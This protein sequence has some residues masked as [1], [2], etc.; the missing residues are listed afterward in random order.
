MILGLVLTF[1]FVPMAFGGRHVFVGYDVSKSMYGIWEKEKMNRINHYLDAILFSGLPK[2]SPKDRIVFI[3]K[4]YFVGPLLKPGDRLSFVR[5][6]SPP[7]PSPK[8]SEPYDGSPILRKRLLSLLP[9]ERG[10]F[11][12]DWT[13]IELLQWRAGD[14]FRQYPEFKENLLVLISDK[15]ESRYPLSVEDQK[16]ILWYKDRYDE[17]IILDIQVGVVHLEVSE[18]IPPMSGIKILDP[19]PGEE[20]YYA[21][22][23]IPVRINLKREGK[24]LKEKGWRVVAEIFPKGRPSQARETILNDD[25]FGKDMEAGDGVYTG[26]LPGV[27]EREVALRV[28]ATKGPIEFQSTELKLV[29]SSPPGPPIWFIIFIL[30]MGGLLVHYW[31]WPMRLWVE[32]EG[33]PPRRVELKR[34]GDVLFLGKR[35]GE[36]YVDIGLPRY[37]ILRQ[38][39]REVVLWG[40]GKEEGKLIPWDRWFSPYEDE[41]VVLRFSLK[42]PEKGGRKALEV[43]KGVREG[44]FYKW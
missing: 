11:E 30:M 29:L 12:Q 19:R 20:A 21:G 32:R 44:D 40:E 31:L 8:L 13:C 24:V 28:K 36:P 22:R 26:L 5:F 43:P 23:P 4:G 17:R 35:E 25:G 2:I 9:K 6:G 16:R 42:R 18:I 3:K 1:F 37:S 33:L 38:K 34:V 15:C 27:G 14:F 39:R 7:I 10:E 41:E